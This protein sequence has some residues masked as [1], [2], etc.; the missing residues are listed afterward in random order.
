MGERGEIH[1]KAG[2]GSAD[3]RTAKEW[4]SQTTRTLSPPVFVDQRWDPMGDLPPSTVLSAI[5]MDQVQ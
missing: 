4:W 5:S 1:Q 3:V 2:R